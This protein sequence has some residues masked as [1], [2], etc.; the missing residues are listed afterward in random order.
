MWK[1]LLIV[2]AVNSPADCA[3][4]PLT[5]T[6]SSRRDC[7]ARIAV[8]VE[9]LPAGV[10]PFEGYCRGGSDSQP[11]HTRLIAVPVGAHRQVAGAGS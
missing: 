11:Q 6:F 2:C 5:A 10:V 9:T 7:A 4:W 1:A 3:E 8:T